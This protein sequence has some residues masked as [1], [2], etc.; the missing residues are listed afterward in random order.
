LCVLPAGSIIYTWQNE[1]FK[2][3]SNYTRA[4][5]WLNVLDRYPIDCQVWLDSL[6][7][8]LKAGNLTL[9]DI[10]TT[11]EKIEALRLKGCCAAALGWFDLVRIRPNNSDIWVQE[12]RREL[13][14]GKLTLQDL[15]KSEVEI[16]SLPKTV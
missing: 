16:R 4:L 12:M 5:E 11:N 10:G 1:V 15:G 13:A 9:E 2:T 6:W 8:E 14:A 7:S 3:N